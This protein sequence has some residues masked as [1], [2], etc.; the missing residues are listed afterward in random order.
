MRRPIIITA[1]TMILISLGL[2]VL[3]L[4]GSCRKQPVA[5]EVKGPILSM[6]TATGYDDRGRPQNPSFSFAPTEP[7]WSSSCRSGN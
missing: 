1:A 2:L 5:V 7:R 4:S 6:T 3:L